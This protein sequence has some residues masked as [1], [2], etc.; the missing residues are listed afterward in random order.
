MATYRVVFYNGEKRELI[1]DNVT[2]VQSAGDTY[3]FKGQNHKEPLAGA[4]KEK[5]L[6]FEKISE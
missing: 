2:S 5:V 1:I 3:E 4:P 6:Y